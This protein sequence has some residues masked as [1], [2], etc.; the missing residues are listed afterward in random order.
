MDRYEFLPMGR[1][2][3]WVI[4]AQ[5]GLS[6]SLLALILIENPAEQIGLL[7]LIG[8]LINSFAATQD[9]AV[10]GMSI[11]LTAVREQ[12]RLNA[13]MS[14]GKA[15]GWSVTA[16]ISGVLLTTLGMKATAILAAAIASIAAPACQRPASREPRGHASA[17]SRWSVF[18]GNSGRYLQYIRSIVSN[19]GDHD[20]SQ[21]QYNYAV[22]G[23]AN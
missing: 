17:S 1:R 3:P 7:M 22:N 15:V 14:F 23:C 5:L 4:G 8:V 2:R 18:G 11:D 13:F 19:R 10:D 20:Q 21:Q 12:G 6:L 9:V 16:A